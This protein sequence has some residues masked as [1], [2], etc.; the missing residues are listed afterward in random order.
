MK[1][2]T[3]IC[4]LGATLNLN[5]NASM[6]SDLESLDWQK[7]GAK[8]F[9]LQDYDDKKVARLPTLTKQQIII[10]AKKM[11]A[12][13]DVSTITNTESA[14]KYLLEAGFELSVS[15]FTVNGKEF[16]EVKHW[17]GDNPYGIIFLKDTL[18]IVAANEDGSIACY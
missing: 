8:G 15:H 6:C 10:A 17:P 16:T 5:A 9:D 13:E 4:L 1:L 14:V 3:L 7:L 18:H 12:E 11:A 2:I